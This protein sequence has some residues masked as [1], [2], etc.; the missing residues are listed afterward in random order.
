MRHAFRD[1][2]RFLRGKPIRG[3]K[4]MQP[5]R[6]APRPVA[7]RL[8]GKDGRAEPGNPA[9]EFETLR[10]DIA[11]MVRQEIDRLDGYLAYHHERTLREL[12]ARLGPRFVYSSPTVD[13][14]VQEAGL[15]YIIPTTQVH[16]LGYAARHGIAGVEP[17]MRGLIESTVRPGMTVVE[18]GAGFGLHTLPLAAAVGPSGRVESFETE[19]AMVSALE[20]NIRLNGFAGRVA[21][22]C[23]MPGSGNA[24]GAQ[25]AAAAA[26]GVP[27]DDRLR[28][29]SH[30]D[31]V[32]I[33]ADDAMPDV[34]AGMQR[35]L[36][37]NSGLEIA[38][39]WSAARLAGRGCDLPT[40]QQ[41]VRSFG[42]S[43][44][45]APEMMPVADLS[46]VEDGLLL[47]SRTGGGSEARR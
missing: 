16:L 2:S 41:A 36:K 45:L 1:L 42:F 15:D 7:A 35:I 11:A 5:S 29:G 34:L 20:R 23:E 8:A 9:V 22:H 17:D 30:V 6:P 24:S 37:E 31:F 44:C 40:A 46:A 27:L 39:R 38:C 47:F 14:V 13:A 10:Q 21:V 43:S 12:D 3:A 19:P 25:A 4:A 18:V 32:V 33:H 28:P 26:A